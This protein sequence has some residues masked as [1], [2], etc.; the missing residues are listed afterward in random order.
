MI[1]RLWFDPGG[2]K[3]CRE[4]SLPSGRTQIVVRLGGTPL[5][6]F[7][8]PADRNGT[9][10][11]HASVAGARASLCVKDS[12]DRPAIGAVLRPG[13]L[14]ALFGVSAAEL[15]ERHT[16]LHDLMSGSPGLLDELGETLE[17]AAMLK[18]LG[19][20]LARMAG[21]AR[22]MHPAIAAMLDASH[23]GSRVADVMARTG[24]SHRHVTAAFRDAT[25]LTPKR[26][27]RV[28]RFRRLLAAARAHPDRPW[29]QL[30]FEVGY[31]DQ[32]HLCREF[33]EFAGVTP[34][35]YRRARPVY[36]D[37]LPVRS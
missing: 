24:F 21:P 5:T 23:D 29:S 30:A 33:V 36:E 37:H 11:G 35:T 15:A 3:S 10:V 25:G 31:A 4:H 8:G 28:Q 6:V 22:A 1:D 13:A 32:A 34:E 27:M 9:L 2:G 19:H 18:L 26:Y 12:A 7:D 14:P 16:P 17:P 20:G